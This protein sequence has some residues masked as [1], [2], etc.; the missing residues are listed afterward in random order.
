[1]RIVVMTSPWNEDDL[2]ESFCR[3]TRTFCDYLLV[4][5]QPQSD[6]TL[7]ILNLLTQDDP[8]IVLLS[9]NMTHTDEEIY[10]S[11]LQAA[12]DVYNADL[13][14]YLDPDEFLFSSSGKNPR[15]ELEKLDPATQ[16]LFQWQTFIYNKDPDDDS[17]FLPDFF[18]EFRTGDPKPFYKTCMS[19]LL[20]RDF[21]ARF[22]LGNH[23]LTFTSAT[24]PDSLVYPKLQ[25]GH[26]PLRS[27]L[28]TTAKI[29]T[30]KM[31]LMAKGFSADTG[32]Q[33]SDLY[34]LIK[35]NGILPPEIIRKFSIYYAVRPNCKKYISVTAGSMPIYYY[36]KP[37]LKYTMY[38]KND[39]YLYIIQS[40]LEK[41]ELIVQQ[42]N[43]K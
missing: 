9:K 5:Q 7:E 27:T 24:T 18:K 19:R 39:P 35:H 16:Y 8:N 30:G 31:A 34:G 12:F 14:L 3:H 38:T 17:R 1:M 4:W 6:R 20:W 13:L 42:N 15:I 11:R 26:Y 40:L 41:F 28:Q 32:F 2:I 21:G 36:K 29:L 22:A 23:S 33:W 25:I 37:S 43:K 10:A